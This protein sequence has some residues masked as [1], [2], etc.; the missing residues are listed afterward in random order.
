L[1][2]NLRRTPLFDTDR[3]RRHIEQAYVTMVD[4]YRRGE[5][6]RSFTVGRE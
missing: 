4:R 2:E 3:F 1:Q 5:V 6:A